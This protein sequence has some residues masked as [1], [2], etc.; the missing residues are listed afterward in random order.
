MSNRGATNGVRNRRR[1]SVVAHATEEPSQGQEAPRTRLTPIFEKLEKY[2][3]YITASVLFI[4]FLL[5]DLVGKT[6]DNT[7][8]SE[9]VV[10]VTLLDDPWMISPAAIREA[11][12]SMTLSQRQFHAWITCSADVVFPLALALCFLGPATK[13]WKRA[14]AERLLVGM[15][16]A[17]WAEGVVQVCL[18]LGMASGDPICWIKSI[19]TVVKFILALAG[20]LPLACQQI[21]RLFGTQQQP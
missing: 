17:D 16:L 12:D 8:L 1:S 9:K 11:L 13:C 4:A 18:L 3:P 10:G 19:L 14:R 20:G 6:N 15:V 5:V 21:Q 7:R 2:F